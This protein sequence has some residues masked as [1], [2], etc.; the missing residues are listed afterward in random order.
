MTLLLIIVFHVLL[1]LQQISQMRYSDSV[2]DLNPFN[3]FSWFLYNVS[4]TS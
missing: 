3:D 1:E 2:G 4:S